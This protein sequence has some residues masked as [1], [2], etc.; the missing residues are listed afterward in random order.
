MTKK[1]LGKS[2]VAG[3]WLQI[4]SE[5]ESDIVTN[6]TCVDVYYNETG[7]ALV[8]TNH[9]YELNLNYSFSS[10]SAGMENYVLNFMYMRN[11]GGDLKPDWGMWTF[12]CNTKTPPN[13]FSGNFRECDK[14]YKFKGYKITDKEDLRLLDEDFAGNFKKVLEKNKSKK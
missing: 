9:D 12:Q 3:R 5:T 11:L 4:I 10:Y 14:R 6:Y 2:Y 13:T 8:G 1:L 7:I